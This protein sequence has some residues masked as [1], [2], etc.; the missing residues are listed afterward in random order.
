MA[1]IVLLHDF[2]PGAAGPV[3]PLQRHLRA[4][5]RLARQRRHLATL[6]QPLAVGPTGVDR[7]LS[8]YLRARL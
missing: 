1:D 2:S 3:R 6:S 5:L 7:W 4:R 8:L